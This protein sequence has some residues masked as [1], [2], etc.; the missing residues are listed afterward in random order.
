M[1]TE[2]ERDREMREG[3]GE[4]DRQTSSLGIKLVA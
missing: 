1:L 3:G 2:R 4:A